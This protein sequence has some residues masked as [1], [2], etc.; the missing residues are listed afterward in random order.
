MLPLPAGE[1]WGEGVNG[2][3]F[4]NQQLLENASPCEELKKED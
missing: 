1:G 3:I 4:N 2:Q